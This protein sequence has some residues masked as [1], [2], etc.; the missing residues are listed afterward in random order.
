MGRKMRFQSI[1]A[2]CL[3]GGLGVV[4]IFSLLNVSSSGSALGQVM[5]TRRMG[6]L[7]EE[8]EG[9]GTMPGDLSETED[10]DTGDVAASQPDTDDPEASMPPGKDDGSD[11]TE[12]AGTLPGDLSETADA[13]TGDADVPTDPNQGT[14]GTTTGPADVPTDPN[15]GPGGADTGPAPTE[16]DD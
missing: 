3:I 15:Q 2:R 11:G 13:D 1:A 12:G 16:A 7:L 14:E 5:A 9:A 10:P 6:R 8:T 4:M